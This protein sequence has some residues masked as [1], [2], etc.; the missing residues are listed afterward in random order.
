MYQRNK[1][2]NHHFRMIAALTVGLIV[3]SLAPALKADETNKKTNI[4]I[5]QAIDVQGTVLPP[6]SY[7]LKV[8][9]SF[10]DRHIVQIFNADESHLITTILATPAYRLAGTS[11][12]EFKFYDAV[13]GRP[14]ALHTWF[15]PGDNFGTEF[16]SAQSAAPT[17]SGRRHSNPPASSSAGGD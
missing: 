17:Q 9:G 3:S 14:A 5:D 1:I 7:V 12:T 16:G 11:D 15:Y 2:V 13:A 6:G 4:K 8:L 10:S